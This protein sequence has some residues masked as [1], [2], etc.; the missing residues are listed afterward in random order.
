MCPN[1]FDK[2]GLIVLEGGDFR[3]PARLPHARI[4]P[5]GEKAHEFTMVASGR[6]IWVQPFGLERWYSAMD[7]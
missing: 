3:L 7:L 6:E 2:G 5:V 1:L 4:L